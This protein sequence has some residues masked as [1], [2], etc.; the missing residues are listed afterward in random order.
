MWKIFQKLN[1]LYRCCYLFQNSNKEKATLRYVASISISQLDIILSYSLF[2]INYLS[3][4]SKLFMRH[5]TYFQSILRHYHISLKITC[6]DSSVGRAL[7]WRSKGP[8]FDPGS[9]HFLSNSFSIYFAFFLFLFSQ[10][11]TIILQ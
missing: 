7:D 5:Q 6:R 9:R 10:K 11:Y 2:I 4:L 1:W 3:L 8:R